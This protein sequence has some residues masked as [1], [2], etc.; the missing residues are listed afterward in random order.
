MIREKGDCRVEGNE[1]GSYNLYHKLLCIKS[2]V[3][4]SLPPSLPPSLYYHLSA[5]VFNVLAVLPDDEAAYLAHHKA[6]AEKRL[7]VERYDTIRIE[8]NRDAEVE[9]MITLC[10]R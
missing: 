4:L 1:E 10:R 7:T 5:Q 3:I 8:R 6:E 2:C 9:R